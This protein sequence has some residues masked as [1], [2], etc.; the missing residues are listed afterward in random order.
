MWE[1]GL[2]V[3]LS[4]IGPILVLLLAGL[5]T[6]PPNDARWLR[7]TETAVAATTW[8][9][10]VCEL[11]FLSGVPLWSRQCRTRP[12][13][14][15]QSFRRGLRIAQV[16]IAVI[17]P[18]QGAA[19][20]GAL[21]LADPTELW[22][23]GIFTSAGG[24]IGTVVLLTSGLHERPGVYLTLRAA[25]VFPEQHPR[26]AQVLKEATESV[27]ALLPVI[28]VG[29]RAESFST[30]STVFCPDGEFR[31]GV[32]YLSL[33]SS[34]ILSITEFRA[35]AGEALMRLQAE[36]QEARSEFHSTSIAAEDAVN[37][38]DDTMR[39]WSWWPKFAFPIQLYPFWLILVVAIRFPMY[40][41]SQL[42]KYYLREF[43]T[44]RW[45][46]DSFQA[47]KEHSASADEVGAIQAIS[48]RV[49]EAAMSLGF[50]T[51]D[52]N[53]KALHPLGEIAKRINQ[54]HPNLM[55]EDHD[56]EYG[57]RDTA[58]Q[59][60]QSRCALSGASL[61]WCKRIALEVN[62][63]PAAQSLFEDPE[64]LQARLV[65]LAN[66]PFVRVKRTE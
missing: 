3:L 37:G 49:K 55:L 45:K 7:S 27:G 11:A 34:A 25:R 18:V 31:E 46:A 64:G 4:L 57:N 51:L 65:E 30:T 13:T 17:I 10:V 20:A 42:L 21:Y 24:V 9:V 26:L 59:Y 66:E 43:W 39:Q 15:T 2:P 14:L 56:P 47:A 8:F 28:L 60:L 38:I 32:L 41:G 16:L 58:W 40:F 50:R 36:L 48:A 6:P 44:S 22:F 29:L 53:G 5:A 63:E 54:E 23:W 12:L 35:L 61:E 1:L 19:L 33:P 52:P 62:P